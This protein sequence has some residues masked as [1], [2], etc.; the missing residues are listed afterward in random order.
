RSRSAFALVGE[1]D[2]L[3]ATPHRDQHDLGKLEQD[4]HLDHA[5]PAAQELGVEL[6]LV[7]LAAEQAEL[8]VVARLELL[9]D[10]VP[11]LELEVLD[12]DQPKALEAREL[13][14]LQLLGEELEILGNR[15]VSL[16]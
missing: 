4:I 5:G 11:E 7:L 16:R 2:R 13:G 14:G 12:L 1:D 6:E 10:D 9:I 8:H 3:I 15:A